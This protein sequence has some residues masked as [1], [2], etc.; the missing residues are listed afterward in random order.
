MYKEDV[1]IRDRQEE[2]CAFVVLVAIC[3]GLISSVW[4]Y[5][6][7]SH[8]LPRGGDFLISLFS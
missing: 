5:G 8:G 1:K 4:L 7:R 3:F 2:A 6:L